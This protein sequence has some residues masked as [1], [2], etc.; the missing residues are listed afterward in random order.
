VPPEIAAG[1]QERLLVKQRP[2]DDTREAVP[3]ISYR[4]CL[5][6]VRSFYLD[7]AQW[8]LEARHAGRT[9]SNIRHR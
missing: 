4:E 7:L 9:G 8:A 5:V 1:W 6:K 3:R 2:G